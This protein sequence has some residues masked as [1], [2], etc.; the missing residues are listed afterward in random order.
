VET[1]QLPGYLIGGFSDGF[2]CHLAG[3][4]VAG[5]PLSPFSQTSARQQPRSTS[6]RTRRRGL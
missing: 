2:L 5:P 6:G 1:D 3:L 4:S